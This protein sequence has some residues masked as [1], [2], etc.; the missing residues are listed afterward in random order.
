LTILEFRNNTVN[1]VIS[2]QVIVSIVFDERNNRYINNII[3]RSSSIVFPINT[4][5]FAVRTKKYAGIQD[6]ISLKQSGHHYYYESVDV[7]NTSHA[8]LK[9]YKNDNTTFDPYP[10]VSAKSIE[11]ETGLK[12]LTLVADVDASALFDP[13]NS[14]S[15]DYLGVIPTA[16]DKANAPK[17][18]YSLYN[19]SATGASMLAGTDQ[20]LWV[21][22]DRWDELSDLGNSSRV[23]YIKSNG[24]T[25]NAGT[26]N[27]L[28]YGTASSTWTED[29]TFNQPQFDY[30]RGSWFGG[31]FEAFGKED[32]LSFVWTPENATAFQSDHLALVDKKRVNGLYQD[33][34]YQHLQ[35][36]RLQCQCLFLQTMAS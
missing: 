19:V 17:S 13:I 30:I 18:I 26:D 33:K 1:P 29:I 11:K 36:P 16:N 22:G 10:T 25:L 12:N 20:G 21:Y 14:I 31:T 23:Y 7:A 2:E 35:L 4:Q 24:S 15:Y 34:H 3:P 28:W 9:L 6:Y 5:V 27:N 8:A 32:G